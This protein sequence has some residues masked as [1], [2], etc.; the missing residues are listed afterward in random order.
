MNRHTAKVLAVITAA[1]A[2]STALRAQVVDVPDVISPLREET[3]R[4]GVN[5]IGGK[6][7]IDV[8][9]LSVPGAPNLKFDRVQ[10][11]TPYV[12]GK[13]SGSVGEYANGNYSVQT[14]TGT[15]E[16][17]QCLDDACQSVT[18]TGSTLVGNGPFRFRQTKTGAVFFFNLKHIKT[19]GSNPNTV[20]YYASSITYPNGE[21]ITF[22]YDT[23]M[24][25]GLTYYRPTQI[26]SNLGFFITIAYHGNTIGVDDWN[27]PS[28]AA[29]YASAD[30]ATPLGRL[31][32]ATSNGTTT[33]TDL[34]G[35]TYYCQGC[36]NSMHTYLETASGMFQLPGEGTA[37]RQVVN[38]PSKPLVSSVTKDGVTWNYTYTNL[39][40][41]T[42]LQTY[43]YDR[44]TV[45][46][47][48]GY[49][50]AYNM[51][52]HHERNALSSITDSIGRSTAYHYDFAYRV[53][54]AV[55]PESNEA[56]V[57]Y[58]DYGNITSR[59][60]TAK[61]G[62]GLAAISESAYY[63]TTSCA[64][65]SGGPLC[66]RPVWFRDAR[67]KQTD[68]VYN[69]AGQ[70]TERTDPADANGVRR[71]TYI[72]YE[73]STGVS[74]KEAVRVCGDTTTCGTPAE[75]RTEYEYWGN[76][77]LPSVVRRID[78]A[79]SE[80][81]ETHYSYDAAG[82]MLSEDGPLPGTSDAK[83]FR[84]D[85]HGRKKWEIGP[86]GSNGLRNASY[87]E[88]RNSDDQLLYTESGTVT[89]PSST[90]LTVYTRTDVTYDS[91]RNPSSEAISASG[92]TYSLIQRSFDDAGRPEC[93]ARRMNPAAF[94]SL[95]GACTLGTEGG[96]GPDRIT[97]K[98]HN[99]AGELLVVQRAYGTPLQQNY[100]TYTYSANGKRATVTDA[101]GNRAEMRYDGHD[102]QNRWVF[103]S[104]TTPG[105]VN[106][107]DYE[108]YTYDA[109]GNRLSLRKRDGQTLTYN[110][111]GRNRVS[112]KTV[113]SSATGAAGYAVHYGYDVD[114][115]QLFARFGSTSGVGITNV[116]DGFGRLRTSTNNMGGVSRML[117]SDYDA[118]SRRNRLTFPDSN[119][120]T[121]NHDGA[122]R[123]TG[124]LESGATTV[125]DFFYDDLGRRADAW[126]G[127]AVMSNEY[128]SISR[129]SALAHELSG[130]AADQILTFGYNPASQVITRGESNDAYVNI[131]PDT[132]ARSYNV[133]GLNQYT[134]VAGSVHTYD[135]NGNL[136]SGNL[137]PE[138]VTNFVYDAENRL[139]SA[140]GAKNATLAYDPMGRLFQISGGGS[141][142][143]FL[144][145]GD[146][147]VAEYSG[148]ALM[149]RYVHGAGVDEPLLWY[150]GAGLTTRR[151]LFANHQGSIVAVADANGGVVGVNAYDAYGVPGRPGA[152]NIGRFQY[153]GQ[154][155][156]AE[157]ELYHYKA[158]FYSATLGRF[159][160]TDPIG[161]DDNTNLYAYVGN[162]PINSMDPSGT[163]DTGTNIKGAAASD[164]KVD[165]SYAFA[166]A[167]AASRKEQA[168]NKAAEQQSQYSVDKAVDRLNSCATAQSQ[169][170]CA[171]RVREAVEAGGIAL[172]RTTYAKDYGPSLEKAGFRQ[173]DVG[174]DYQPQKGDIVVMQGISTRPEGHM[175]M[176][177]GER[178]V[179]DFNQRL[180]TRPGAIWP[181]PGYERERPSYEVYRYGP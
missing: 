172:D 30:P 132:P 39:R 106:E 157:L 2:F 131:T 38:V 134:S 181:G 148:G 121:F 138:G 17:F 109:A 51:V 1:M 72:E 100:A 108:S 10:N 58:D 27:S 154:I 98:V 119:Y 69:A 175:Q 122:G 168:D 169:G 124:I 19:T 161:Y 47:P 18:G 20:L 123:L 92:T 164:C 113:P 163:C 55:Y 60:L 85:V 171:T 150:E 52:D 107:S 14:G 23:A 101:N 93:E 96:F 82:R 68:F 167:M 45:T 152:G 73:T 4:N 13:M 56:S 6:L 21:T 74:R 33:I 141:T 129:L 84:Y 32:Y 144:Y 140:S 142:T 135:L 35:R 176:N 90:S 137:T 91:R 8:P 147:L 88:Y 160:Q 139:V 125:A 37:S 170:V 15:S 155:W 16:G 36:I 7:T 179:S 174:P 128:D 43:L 65:V 28:V 156:L 162:D 50:V 64:V 44:L 42:T 67:N 81:L 26:T 111:D 136:T 22:T 78:A 143:Q 76:T 87:F 29:I 11:V 149:R 120:F 80:S 97:R 24:L 159:L 63:D 3:D 83:Y 34:G 95:P 116:Y 112:L 57:A 151:G 104:K 70:L 130:T 102:R 41:A 180:N 133:N 25:G 49:N 115:L 173:L 48:N 86:A 66:Y 71:K 53:I 99:A 118:G 40:N 79:R 9:V 5:V 54:R 103:P 127:G 77:L 178:W 165:E 59:T 46:G 110:Y 61:P 31:T 145:D 89:D 75:A 146:K 158:R 117:T 62:S 12:K 114:G 105:S 166:E 177:N 126:V 94:T 153:T